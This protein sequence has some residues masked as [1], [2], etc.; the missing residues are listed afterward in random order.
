MT[1]ARNPAGE[2]F[3]LDA[4]RAAIA[5]ARARPGARLHHILRAILAR[6]RTYRRGERRHDDVTLLGAWYHD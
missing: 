4:L 5:A 3:G 2:E 6:L 1:E